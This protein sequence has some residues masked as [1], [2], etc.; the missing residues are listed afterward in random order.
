M[1]VLRRYRPAVFA[2]AAASLIITAAACSSP[3]A[4]GSPGSSSPAASAPLTQAQLIAGSKHEKGL[5]IYSN[6]LLTQ[7]SQVTKA[8]QVKYPWIHVTAT[9]DEDP[10]IFSKYAAE[11]ATGARTADILVASAPGLWRDSRLLCGRRHVRML[12]NMDKWS[13]A[14]SS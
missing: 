14:S 3:G 13:G 4:Q 11:H 6:A 8:F 7:M 10:V 2:A 1:L 12:A 9:D 5:L